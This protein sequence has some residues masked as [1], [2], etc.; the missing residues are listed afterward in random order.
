MPKIPT[1]DIITY[2]EEAGSGEP[3]LMI[4]GLSGDLQAWA[5][6]VPTL[7]RRYRVITYDNRG[8]GRTSAPDKPYSIK[9]MADD[10]VALL[11][12]L[13]IARAHV[14]GFSMGGY[15][16]QELV[17][18]H[19]ERAEKLILLA[20]APCIDGYGKV[21]VGNWINVRRSNM[22][23]EQIVRYTSQFLYSPELLDDP[24]RYERAVQNNLANPYAQQDHAFIRQAQAVLAFDA[25][26]RLPA[27]KSP[28]L[29]LVGKDDILVPPRNSE[30]LAKLIPGAAMKTLSGGHLG[31]IEY[32]HEY[33]DAI[34][35]FLG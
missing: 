31:C 17:A 2:Y 27:V 25:R 32:P 16:A 1:R 10:A 35:E 15:I 5:L 18:A 22:S 33:N 23:R 6:Q 9:Q 20:T 11:D 19:P 30:K 14:L 8:A 26:D 34:A 29:V 24:E 3:L 28:S 4:M 12:S 7:A 21:V 13:G